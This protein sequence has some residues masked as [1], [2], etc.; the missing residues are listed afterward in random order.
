LLGNRGQYCLE[1]LQQILDSV[2]S[3][4]QVVAIELRGTSYS[5]AAANWHYRCM[6]RVI[7]VMLFNISHACSEVVAMGQQS[8]AAGFGIQLQATS[9][10]NGSSP[11]RRSPA[12]RQAR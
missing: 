7:Y 6:K 2:S 4:S 9:A 8:V 10:K 3:N 1:Q 11:Y 5:D 12:V